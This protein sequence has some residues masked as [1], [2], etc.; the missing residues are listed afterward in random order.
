M[1]KLWLEQVSWD[2]KISEDLENEWLHMR[3][4]FEHINDISIDRW[5]HTTAENKENIQLHGFSDASSR[6]YAAVVYVKVTCLN[7]DIHT[8]L[9][10]ARTR[11]APL[12][13]ISIP[14]LELCGALLLSQ[15]LTHVGRAMK[16]PKSQTFAWTD[17]SIVLAW[18]SGEP[19]R[20]KTFVANRVVEILDNISRNQ[21]YHVLSNENPA[22]IA[23]RG[24]PVV[25]LKACDL[26]WK[27]PSWL[28]TKEIK[29]SRLENT[30]TDEERK[31]VKE[32]QANVKINNT[33]N[34]NTGMIDQFKQ[35]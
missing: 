17:S 16:I 32:L 8:S 9:I 6:A 13:T 3:S 14:R 20:W 10:A 26:W 4:D 12:K 33:E 5:I 35:F 30:Q 22:D 18:L 21:W 1:Q 29:F 15:L 19:S 25:E 24:L 27:G 31:I 34:D 28:S 2:D 23:S 7:R 11:V